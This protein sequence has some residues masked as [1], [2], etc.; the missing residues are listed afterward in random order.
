MAATTSTSS[1]AEAIAV[2]SL[3]GLGSLTEQQVRGQACV[4]D[5]VPL[6]GV[7]AV[8]LGEQKVSRA[9]Q[10]TRWFPRACPACVA[11]AA[12][13]ALHEHAPRCKQCV[14]DAARCPEGL[15]LRRLMRDVRR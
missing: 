1:M 13:R 9:G 3:P 5:A 11:A 15:V 6:T 10:L 8:D 14:D 7:P 4:W 2:L 12:L